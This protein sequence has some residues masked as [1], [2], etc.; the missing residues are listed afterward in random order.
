[1]ILNREKILTDTE[2]LNALV[3]YIR[4]AERYHLSNAKKGIPES[5]IKSMAVQD[6][7]SYIENELGIEWIQLPT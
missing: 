5:A 7:L 4:D 6:I 3:D 2:K 1:V